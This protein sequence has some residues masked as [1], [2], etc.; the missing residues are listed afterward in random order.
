MDIIPPLSQLV[1]FLLVPVEVKVPFIVRFEHAVTDDTG[2]LQL[3][4]KVMEN[5]SLFIDF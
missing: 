5:L 4:L 2:F 1:G 3:I